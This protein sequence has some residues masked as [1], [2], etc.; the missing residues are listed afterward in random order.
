[1]ADGA[2]AAGL[3]PE[4]PRG[5][6][7][8]AQALRDQPRH[9]VARAARRER[10]DDGDRLCPERLLAGRRRGQRHE[11]EREG[12]KRSHEILQMLSRACECYTLHVTCKQPWRIPVPAAGP[13]YDAVV[14]DLLTALLD[15]WTLWNAVAGSAADGLRWRRTYLDLTYRAGAY[16]PYEAIVREAATDA[17]LDPSCADELV[18]RWGELAPW[19]EAPGIIAELGRRV[20]LGV[21]TNCSDRL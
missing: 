2:A 13:R 15:S 9:G 10:H 21:A 6:R 18:R 11:A 17:G 4:D 20:P 16:R 5:G 19:P 1:A 14:F 8:L 3:V 7:R 12:G